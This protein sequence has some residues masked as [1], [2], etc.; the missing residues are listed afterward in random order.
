[1]NGNATVAS[2]LTASTLNVTSMS[3]FTNGLTIIGSTIINGNATVASTLIV[4]H[5]DVSSIKSD[6]ISISNVNLD[7]ISV[8]NINI[9]SIQP[10]VYPQNI[11]GYDVSGSISNTSTIANTSNVQIPNSVAIDNNGRVTYTIPLD[12]NIMSFEMIGAGG[13]ATSDGN[14]KYYTG[15][16]TG[17]YIKGNINAVPFRGKTLT[18]QAGKRDYTISNYNDRI[19]SASVLSFINDNEIIVVAG[20][21]GNAKN[22]SGFNSA[23]GGGG[24]GGIFD[25]NGISL[26]S[27]GMSTIK[28]NTQSQ[29]TTRSTTTI[30]YL[31]ESQSII[32]GWYYVYGGSGHIKGQNGDSDKFGAD[33]GA[34][35]ISKQYVTI[36]ESYN[37]STISNTPTLSN[38][39]LPGYGRSNMNGYV[40][41]KIYSDALDI[42]N[43]VKIYNDLTVSGSAILNN[44][45]TVNGNATVASTLTASTLN[46]TSMS[47]FTNGLT[48]AGSTI[49]NGNATVA[50]T[51]TASTLTVSTLTANTLTASTIQTTGNVIRIGAVDTDQ[52]CTLFFGGSGNTDDA[53][54]FGQ[55]S[56]FGHAFIRTRPFSTNSD[57]SEML[58]FKGNDSI[59]TGLNPNYGPDRIRLRAGAIVFDT[60]STTISAYNLL[61]NSKTPNAFSENPR[62]IINHNGNV[63]IGN[64]NPQFIL[65]VTGSAN[66]SQSLTVSTL[67]VNQR[68]IINHNGNV[69]IGNLNPQ[70]ILD[71]T[72][73]ANISQAL[74]VSTLFVNQPGVGGRIYLGGGATNDGDYKNSVITTRQYGTNISTNTGANSFADQYATELLLYKGDETMADRIRLR[75]GAI[76]FDTYSNN[77]YDPITGEQSLN[78]VNARMTIDN[79]GNVGINT[80]ADSAFKLDVNGVARFSNGV[81]TTNGDIIV[82]GS[83]KIGINLSNDPDYALDVNGTANITQ[84]LTVSTLQATGNVIRIGE[85]DTDQECTLFFGGGVNDDKGTNTNISSYGHAFIRTRPYSSFNSINGF[86]KLSEML[87]FKGNDSKDNPTNNNPI[88]GD[89]GPDRIRLRAG[90]ICFDTYDS[91][92]NQEDLLDNSKGTNAFTESIRMTINN[93]GNVGIGTITPKFKLDVSGQGKF[94]QGL[95]ANGNIIVKG[96][97]R[98]GINVPNDTPGFALDVVGQGKFTQG[99]IASG[100]IITENA[101]LQI[102]HLNNTSAVN[103]RINFFRAYD[104]GGSITDLNNSRLGQI[105][106]SGSTTIGNVSAYRRA[107]AIECDITNLI[108][109]SNN[110]EVPGRLT[111]KTFNNTRLTIDNNVN[112]ST[113]LNV[114]G[115]ANITQSL[116]VSTLFVNQPSSGGTIYL[117]GG[118]TNDGDYKNSVI[119]TRRYTT[120]IGANNSE[121]TELLL[122]KGDETGF[123]RIRL[124]AGAIVFDTMSNNQ[125]D[126]I[127]GEESLSAEETRMI[128][129]N[130]GLIRFQ[131]LT[132]T[133]N[134]GIEIGAIP[135]GSHN[136]PHIKGFDPSA[137][138]SATNENTSTRELLL[139]KDNTTICGNDIYNNSTNNWIDNAP[140]PGITNKASLYVGGK[141]VATNYFVKIITSTQ[142]ASDT[143]MFRGRYILFKG[144]SNIDF[145]L[146]SAAN[147]KLGAYYKVANLTSASNITFINTSGTNI[148]ILYPS[149]VAEL[150][151]S[152][153]DTP[154][155]WEIL[156]P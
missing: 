79:N 70:F 75:A 128:I 124:R 23:I 146:P 121:A 150:I 28:A 135:I 140:P 41:I 154:G 55:P 143:I 45:L 43:Y 152:D 131:K 105:E 102:Y 151:A 129:D 26:G 107:A 64:L 36:V 104:E 67:Q 94:T 69:G 14:N 96:S 65:D 52:E 155:T 59:N 117:G 115:S 87:I 49:M 1:M 19:N 147:A 77:Q 148:L 54:I 3:N 20:S 22:D 92:I 100:N 39:I 40:S 30:G 42:N 33:G 73:S 88:T 5:L 66:I 38:T 81:Q 139:N 46:V 15:G 116:T 119:T 130:A 35:Y 57:F 149:Q 153:Q 34:S 103:S 90:N 44:G 82:K 111:F 95:E 31:D 110:T 56:T 125:Y 84:A 91:N 136:I 86:N 27:R 85:V 141:F 137:T 7:N 156:A 120:G 138:T 122:Y 113:N 9:S 60:Y 134:A 4:R 112:V 118:A 106:F 101:R 93:L 132:N 89:S 62:M 97:G 8:P 127:T 123:D 68:M 51:L 98:I 72:G 80:T 13:F 25:V 142:Y 32:P 18:I 21:G 63:G 99:I 71:V 53:G 145:H 29:I 16:G 58:L 37:G 24:G 76:V 11:Y 2:T 47:N 6:N 12:A 48:I 133:T 78:T 144:T 61:D 83:G 114:S 108:T 50:S 126:P 10:Y 17:G 109:D 74:T